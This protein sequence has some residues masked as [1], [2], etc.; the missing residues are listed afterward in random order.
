MALTLN[1]P[2]LSEW[3]WV[4]VKFFCI[5]SLFPR[6]RAFSRALFCRVNRSFD[7]DA[8]ASGLFCFRVIQFCGAF[9]CRRRNPTLFTC[10]KRDCRG[11]LKMK[12]P[13][14]FKTHFWFI[15]PQ[16]LFRRCALFQQW[17]SW[18]FFKAIFLDEIMWGAII[19]WK[20]VFFTLYFNCA[21][22]MKKKTN[23]LNA[24]R[25]RWL[26]WLSDQT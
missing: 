9:V 23:T 14:H 16:G 24:W 4:D 25:Q 10:A 12:T 15:L 20:R 21:K 26:P 3:S 22:K 2:A 11:L 18:Q 13:R 17:Q 5:K 1:V 8:C 6:D 7:K 19:N